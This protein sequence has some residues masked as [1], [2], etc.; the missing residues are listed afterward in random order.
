MNIKK[1]GHIPQNNVPCTVT[2]VFPRLHEAKSKD[3]VYA[4]LEQQEGPERYQFDAGDYKLE[5]TFGDGG[6]QGFMGQTGHRRED[7]PIGGGFVLQE[8]EDTFLF[9]GISCNLSVKAKNQASVFVEE[10]REILFEDGELKEGRCLN[11]DERNYLVIGS[12][13]RAIRLTWYRRD[14]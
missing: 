13:P 1:Q 6:F 14:R 3:R 10:K 4:F 5:I 11:G 9:C 7:R 12:R 2:A 8:D